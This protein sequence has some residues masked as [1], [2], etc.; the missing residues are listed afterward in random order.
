VTY[1]DS[2]LVAQGG[3]PSKLDQ[4]TRCRQLWPE[5]WQLVDPESLPKR[6]RKTGCWCGSRVDPLVARGFDLA[7]VL[8]LWPNARHLRIPLETRS[9]EQNSR[10]TICEC[11]SLSGPL[12]FE[13]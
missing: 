6:G 8:V 11:S 1:A 13:S 5:R 7:G 9:V 10:L 3:L 4:E 12:L 2:H